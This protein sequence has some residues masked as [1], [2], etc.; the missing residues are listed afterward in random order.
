MRSKLCIK[1]VSFLYQTNLVVTTNFPTKNLHANCRIL[2]LLSFQIVNGP[3]FC[4][5]LTALPTPVTL[6]RGIH[7]YS[8][9]LCFENLPEVHE[10]KD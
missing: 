2:L 3:M 4:V 7:F 8:H 5:F 6:V 10:E 1:K 9:S